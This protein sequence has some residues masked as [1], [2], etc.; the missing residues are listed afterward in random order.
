MRK[1]KSKK[2]K[3]PKKQE[4]APLTEEIIPHLNTT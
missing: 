1:S 4:I 2:N 3:V